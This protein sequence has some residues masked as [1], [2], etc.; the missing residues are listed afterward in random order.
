VFVSAIWSPHH[1]VGTIGVQVDA[2]APAEDQI[3]VP[4]VEGDHTSFSLEIEDQTSPSGGISCQFSG[5]AAVSIQPLTVTNEALVSR[6]ETIEAAALIDD[7]PEDDEIWLC[8]VAKT[9]ADIL[10]MIVPETDWLACAMLA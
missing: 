6:P 7:V 1:Q 8:W 3:A 4:A 9:L 10:E 2:V 5:S